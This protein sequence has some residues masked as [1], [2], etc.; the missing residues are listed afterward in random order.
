MAAQGKKPRDEEGHLVCAPD[1]KPLFPFP[2][3]IFQM[4]LSNGKD[5]KAGREEKKIKGNKIH[6]S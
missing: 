2:T 6:I 4:T 5:T 3:K 1:F